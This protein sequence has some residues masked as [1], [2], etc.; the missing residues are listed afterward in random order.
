MSYLPKK[1][2]VH[3]DFGKSINYEARTNISR[4]LALA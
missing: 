1:L 2:V 3:F 4:N